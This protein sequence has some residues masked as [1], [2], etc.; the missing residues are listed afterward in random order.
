MKGSARISATEF[1]QHLGHWLE[2]AISGATIEIVRNGGKS[3]VLT[4]ARL[5]EPSAETS[6]EID[7]DRFVKPLHACNGTDARMPAI[8]RE[9]ASPYRIASSQKPRMSLAAFR[10]LADK[11]D[12]RMELIDG[13]PIVLASPSVLHQRIVMKLSALFF[14]HLEGRPCEAFCAPFDVP[15]PAISEEDCDSM[16]Q[17]DVLVVCDLPETFEP[18]YRYEGIPR[19]VVEVLSP[20]TRSLDMVRKLAIYMKSGAKEYWIVDPEMRRLIV[21]RFENREYESVTMLSFDDFYDS[22][23]LDGF[24]LDIVTLFSTVRN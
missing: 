14:N 10:E 9:T 11:T 8:L 20:G 7:S 1:K 24:R 21:Y 15:I 13:E 3:A 19:L 16:L 5:Q 22:A 23:A 18:G 2:E 6:I 4:A 12:D 17:P